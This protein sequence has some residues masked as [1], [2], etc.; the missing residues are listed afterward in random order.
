[1]LLDRIMDPPRAADPEH[2]GRRA[3]VAFLLHLRAGR[4]RVQAE[5]PDQ[6][7]LA[8]PA[9]P[10]TAGF[11]PFAAALFVGVQ[12]DGRAVPVLRGAGDAL[13]GSCGQLEA[14]ERQGEGE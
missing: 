7:A 1:M 2:A 13:R 8:E 4:Q 3:H 5:S 14:G 12:G 6:S 11:H 10:R 9:L